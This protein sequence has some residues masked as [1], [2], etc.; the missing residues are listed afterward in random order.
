MFPIAIQE[1][2][3]PSSFP[4]SQ[5]ISQSRH[6]HT[7]NIHFFPIEQQATKNKAH[8]HIVSQNKIKIKLRRCTSKIFATNTICAGLSGGTAGEGLWITK[9]GC[10]IMKFWISNFY[11][12]SKSRLRTGRVVELG[13]EEPDRAPADTA[14][15]KEPP[16]STARRMLDGHGSHILWVFAVPA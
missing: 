15:V 14:L 12:L 5:K 13:C 9:P 3:T 2:S 16:K 6:W 8:Q 11:F 10:S 7:F 4:L 1:D